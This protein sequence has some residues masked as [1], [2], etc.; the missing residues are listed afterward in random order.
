[1]KT[2]AN[3]SREAAAERSSGSPVSTRQFPITVLWVSIA[4][5]AFHLAYASSALSSLVVVYLFALVQLAQANTWRTAFYSGL[6]VGLLCAIGQLEFFWRIFSGGAVALWLVYAF[7]IGLF[8]VLRRLC[9][10]RLSRDWGWFLLPFIWC[11]LEYFRSELYYLRFSWL[12][13]GFAFAPGSIPLPLIGIYGSGFLLMCVASAGAYRWRKSKWQGI[14]VLLMGLSALQLGGWAGQRKEGGASGRL[15]HVAGVQMEFPTEA[16]VLLRLNTLIREDPKAELVVL[17]EYTFSEP[18][19]AR[20]RNWCRDHARYLIVG[21]TEPA[22]GNAYYNTAFVIGPKGEI[23]FRQVKCVPIQFFKDGLPAPEQ[24]LWESPW[25][26]IGI[27]ICYDLSYTR[28][29]D[30]L[31]KLGAEALVV[32]TMDVADW[33]PQQHELHAR[34]APVRAAEYGIPV[35]RLASSGVSQV[36]DRAGQVFASAPYPGDGAVISATLSLRSPGRLPVDRW[37]APVAT[38]VTA[39]LLAWFLMRSRRW[40]RDSTF[41]TCKG[42]PKR[43]KPVEISC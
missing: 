9:F 12:S 35:F 10:T 20:I 11:G 25:G 18:I 8:A 36:V 40:K 26:K 23:L 38:S 13:A 16:Q 27:C 41:A 3:E 32:P 19:P 6:A 2:F 14:V 4:V 24:R 15:L 42:E 33:G 22:P 5:G 30:Q 37:L 31:V 28:V 34:V 1:M 43:P 29:T 39:A 17:S 21:G 7:W